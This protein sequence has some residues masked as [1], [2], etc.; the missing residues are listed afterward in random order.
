[1]VKLVWPFAI[2]WSSHIIRFYNS[3]ISG[4]ISE[5]CKLSNAIIV[6]LIYVVYKSCSKIIE[7]VFVQIWWYLALLFRIYACFKKCPVTVCSLFAQ[8]RFWECLILTL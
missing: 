1:M 2:F 8:N 6:F 4:Q 5:I 3:L 7:V